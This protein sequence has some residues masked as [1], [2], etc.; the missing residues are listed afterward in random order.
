MWWGGFSEQK[1]LV[2]QITTTSLNPHVVGRFFRVPI[3]GF[4]ACAFSV[5]IPMWWGGFSE[6][7]NYRILEGCEMV[8]IPM[9]WGGFSELRRFWKP[10]KAYSVLIPM[11]WGGFSEAINAAVIVIGSVL[12]PM[13]WGGFSERNRHI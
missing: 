6:Y 1:L 12:I 4:S 13:W 10:C 9:W 5:L 2:Q 8:L 11:W 3:A 7:S